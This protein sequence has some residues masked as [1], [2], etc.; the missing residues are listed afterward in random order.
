MMYKIVLKLTLSS[1]DKDSSVY[2]VDMHPLK[3]V[4]LCILTCLKVFQWSEFESAHGLM[5]RC[6]MTQV[7]EY[8][9][10]LGKRKSTVQASLYLTWTQKFI[11]HPKPHT[12]IFSRFCIS[13]IVLWTEIINNPLRNDLKKNI[14]NLWTA[15][16]KAKKNQFRKSVKSPALAN[17]EKSS[18]T[19][20]L[21]DQYTVQYKALY[22]RTHIYKVTSGNTE[23]TPYKTLPAKYW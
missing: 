12:D 8:E 17:S 3:N 18:K 1:C 5:E 14:S 22:N 15:R 23:D 21:S 2:S 7:W 10:L 13:T 19:I 9:G 16:Q 11:L 4:L 20:P 6:Q